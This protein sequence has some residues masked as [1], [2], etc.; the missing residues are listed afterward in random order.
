MF[1]METRAGAP[2]AAAL[3]R[4]FMWLHVPN[5]DTFAFQQG[6]SQP[7]PRV[8]VPRATEVA[9]TLNSCGRNFDRDF[10]AE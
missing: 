5:G 10:G 9:A 2:R 4:G 3:H 6:G 8:T 7:I 1:P